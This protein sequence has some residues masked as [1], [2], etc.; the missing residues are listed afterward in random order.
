MIS[1]VETVTITVTKEGAQ[2]VAR[3]PF[4]YETKDLVKALGFR[5]DP[6]RKVWWTDKPEIAARVKG[7]NAETVARLNADR[8]AQHAKAEASIVASHATDSEIVIPLS[9]I[10]RRKG[11]DYL[12]YQ[13]AGVA[14]ALRKFGFKGGTHAEGAAAD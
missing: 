14:Y 2:F 7:D 8:Q 9:D 13:R 5:F 12:P 1:G 10:C 4:S 3:F 6:A 11:W